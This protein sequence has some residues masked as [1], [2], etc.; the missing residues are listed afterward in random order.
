MQLVALNQE[1]P[2]VADIECSL[3]R[4][5]FTED[6]VKK[7]KKLYE[8]CLIHDPDNLNPLVEYGEEMLMLFPSVTHSTVSAL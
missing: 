3:A 5:Y 6:S 2:N 4:I 7:A 8:K 1:T